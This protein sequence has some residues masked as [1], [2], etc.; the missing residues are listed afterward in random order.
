MSQGSSVHVDTL[1]QGRKEAHSLPREF[2]TDLAVYQ[3]DLERVWYRQWIFAGHIAEV[4]NPGDYLTVQI[5]EY[6]LLVVRGADG[7]IRALHNVCRHRGSIL[8]DASHGSVRNRIVCPYHQWAYDLDGQL[9]KARKVESDFDPADHGLGVAAC[10][11]TGGM[12]FVCVADSPPDCAP[13][14]E[15]FGRYLA[16]FD[17]ERMKVA[18]R[19]SFVEGGN[20]K[21]VMENNRECFHCKTAHP[22][23]C[24]TFPEAPLHSGGGSVDDLRTLEEMVEE[25][26]ALGLPS[27]FVAAEDWEYRAMRMPLLGGATSM[28]L[29]G[30]PAVAKQFGE[31]PNRDIGDVLLYHYPSTWNHYVAD[32]A[33]TFRIIPRGPMQTELV[34]TWLVPIDAVEGVDYDVEALTNVWRATNAQDAELVERAQRGV[35]SPAYRPG[36]YSTDE[37]AG[38]IQF[39]D[40][41]VATMLR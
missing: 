29:D 41:Y 7:V 8:C 13:V 2:Y 19:S 22:E 12:I 39:I 36:P 17:P 5:G 27:Q 1:L 32:H 11:V 4:Q 21:L 20:W 15:L 3:R 31:L 34:T 38:V 10:E 14:A 33:V 30:R 26:E 28:T 40:W 25:C 37:E 16:P 9:A 6:N 18:H 23:L 24:M 35:S